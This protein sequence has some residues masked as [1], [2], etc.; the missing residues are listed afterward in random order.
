MS[1]FTENILEQAIID[2]FIKQGYEYSF[3]PDLHRR[4][5]DILFL[6]DLKSY[7]SDKYNH[8]LTEN[9]TQKIINEIAFISS[10]PLFE[11]NREVFNKISNGFSIYREDSTEPNLF[12]ELIDFKD[13]RNNKFRII[14]QYEI[15]DIELRIPD[16]LVFINGIP[17]SII[18]IKTAK[19]ESVT[20]FDAWEQIHMR[21]A[22]GIP[23]LLK[24]NFVSVITDGVNTKLGTVFTPYEFY[25]AWKKENDL[26]NDQEGIQSLL[27]AIKGFYNKERIIEI[28]QD[29]IVYPDKGTKEQFPILCRYPQ[30]FATRKLLDSVRVHMKPKGDGKG[31]TYFAATGSGKTY[32]ML[33]LARKLVKTNSEE[34]KNPTV[35][36]IVD[37]EDLDNQ[38]TNLFSSSKKYLN[39]S[40]NVR[41]I[42]SRSDLKE[43]LSS[44]LSGGVFITTIQK[45]TEDTGLLSNRSNIICISDEAHRSQIN[46]GPKVKVSVSKDNK[47]LFTDF[48]TKVNHISTASEVEKSYG[49][50]KYLHDSFPQATYLGFTGTPINETLLV[51][52]DIVDSYT[53]KQSEEDG[54]TVGI[55]Y[56]PALA[57]VILNDEQVKKIDEYYKKCRLLGT[58]NFQ[59][60]QSIKDMTAIDLLLGH[61]DRLEKV[62]KD[63]IAHYEEIERNKPNIVQKA[64][65]VCS[66][67]KIAHDLYKLIL[68]LRSDWG[69]KKKTE[70]DK[71]YSSQILSELPEIEKVKFVATQAPNDSKELFDLA[72]NSDYRRN[73][74]DIFK[75][76]KSNFRIAIV[77]D[78]WLTGFDVPSLSVMYIDKPIQKH[79]LIQTISRV[80]RVFK[81]KDKGV[82]VDYIG[83]YQELLEAMKLYGNI[84]D[85][86]LE[87]INLTLDI[88]KNE[89]AI[90]EE[91]FIG[92]DSHDY[93]FGS[94]LEQLL[95]IDDAVEFV[96]HKKERTT[97][98]LGHSKRLK[99][100]YTL[101]SPAG[102]FL[103]EDVNKANFYFVI[104]SIILKQTAGD[105]PDTEIMNNHVQKMVEEAIQCSG[106]EV[107]EQLGDGEDIFSDEFIKKIEG[108]KLPISKF[109][110]LV[111][112]LRGAIKEFSK[113]NNLKAI[114]YSDKL[115]KTIDKYNN[116]DDFDFVSEA[117]TEFVESLSGELIN[118]YYD[119]AKDRNV[120]IDLGF[121]SP[122]EGAIYD[123]LL[124]VRNDHNF[125]YDEK[126]CILLAKEIKVLIDDKSQYIDYISRED[127]K[128]Q[129]SMDLVRL[130]RKN[131]YP[132]KW[133]IEIF[134]KILIQVDNQ[135]I[136]I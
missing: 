26:G 23:E 130:L 95:C 44:T 20:I 93:Y 21:Y 60:E 126:N 16:V 109:N 132:P 2:L 46:V 64:M 91:M 96:Q 84:K 51:F 69:N 48:D 104:R 71:N 125:D 101:I 61:P 115:N 103:D 70:D 83:F 39:D 102:K 25:Y 82:V 56:E 128:N 79:T 41:S 119:L 50:A 58:N 52:G 67:R 85:I 131:G 124:R 8:S 114:E 11:G 72:G 89:L 111:K 122:L 81:G 118:H 49:F 42:D 77:V 36:I 43:T 121:D 116:R 3:G 29:F 13:F 78:M 117:I 22:R 12:V 53:M 135:K 31:G 66:S 19:D 100:A 99:Q 80:N 30:Y 129:L 55:M 47:I 9:E 88:F 32:T 63:I 33:F 62:A 59:V 98:F 27:S 10:N 57:R 133:N 38:T 76:E 54:I 40:E 92:F 90:L 107:V 35:V 1:N 97:S 15:E 105:T 34:F 17:I 37:R 94:P 7:L 110:A 14:N 123:I 68:A 18:E 127:T 106:V 113:I 108:S 136:N 86:P 24:Y 65:I 112:L 6:D 75:N 120:Y 4:A 134:E 5:K 73:L 45:F 28:L 87:E 74:A